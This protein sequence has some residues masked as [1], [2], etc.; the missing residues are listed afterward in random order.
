FFRMHSRSPGGVTMELLYSML[1]YQKADGDSDGVSR[2]EYIPAGGF[3]QDRW[4]G[5][6]KK[7]GENEMRGC[8]YRF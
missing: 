7:G 3:W 5:E 6:N 8:S 2:G 1:F 4:E